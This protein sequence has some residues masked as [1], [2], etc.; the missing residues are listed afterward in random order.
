MRLK[1]GGQV[2]GEDRS[3]SKGEDRSSKGVGWAVV[4][5]EVGEGAFLGEGWGGPSS[6]SLGWVI[7]EVGYGGQV[8]VG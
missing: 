6:K 1:G 4:E 8:E 7:A 3:S 2:V 5:V